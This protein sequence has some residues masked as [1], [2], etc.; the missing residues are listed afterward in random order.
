MFFVVEILHRLRHE[1]A[2]A[3][4]H[5]QPVDTLSEQIL[6]IAHLPRLVG[7]ASVGDHDLDRVALG[8]PLLGGGAGTVEHG[9]QKRVGSPKDRV[10]DRVTRVRG[11]KA[12]RYGAPGD[13][14]CHR[15]RESQ[16]DECSSLG[17]GHRIRA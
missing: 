13:G 14:D 2:V 11:P 16:G 10:A 3:W 17:L 9:D 5:E 12:R 1:H 6:E 8:L 15:G 7:V 4:E